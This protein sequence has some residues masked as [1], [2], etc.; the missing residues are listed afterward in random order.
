[1]ATIVIKDLTDNTDLDREAMAAI[2]GGARSR[3]AAGMGRMPTPGTRIVDYP[4]GVNRAQLAGGK[5]RTPQ[6]G[7]GKTGK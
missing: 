1:M 6:S 2:T 3:G 4:A 7:P 5:A